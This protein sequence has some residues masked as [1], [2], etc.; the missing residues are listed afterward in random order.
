MKRLV[1]AVALGVSLSA[2]TFAAIGHAQNGPKGQIAFVS[3]R[4]GNEEIY[5]MYTDG[6]HQTNLT[7]N[8]ARDTTPVWSPDGRK[9]AFVSTRDSNEEIYVMN[10]D[11]SGI[12][13]LTRNPA[14]DWCPAWS[15]DGHKLAFASGRSG[16]G[17][18]Y[19][20]DAVERETADER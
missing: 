3:N 4:D 18:I 19:V 2:G 17:D 15:P 8:K 13:N 14:L 11:G 6:S 5:V 1:L 9:I 16:T 12:K 7:N 10:S 20:M